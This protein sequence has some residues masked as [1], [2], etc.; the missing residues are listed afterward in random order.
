M[1][2]HIIIGEKDAQ[3]KGTIANQV[4]TY[5]VGSKAVGLDGDDKERPS[6]IAAAFVSASNPNASKSSGELREMEGLKFAFF[7]LRNAPAGSLKLES[8][9]A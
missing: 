2:A 5:D 4:T 7:L 1:T 3:K 9:S 8:F 6:V